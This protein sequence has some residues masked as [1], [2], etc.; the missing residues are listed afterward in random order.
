MKNGRIARVL[1]FLTPLLAF[2]DHDRVDD[3]RHHFRDSDCV[4]HMA[5][6][7]GAFETITFFAITAVGLWLMIRL[8][9]VR[10]NKP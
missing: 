1:L 9:A 5:E 6:H 4:V 3:C 8:Q 2:A 7:W 10:T